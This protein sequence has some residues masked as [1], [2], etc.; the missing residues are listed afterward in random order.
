MVSLPTDRESYLGGKAMQVYIW[1]MAT[2]VLLGYYG[3]WALALVVSVLVLLYR[4]PQIVSCFKKGE[5]YD[6]FGVYFATKS[7][8]FL[9][10]LWLTICL[11]D[12]GA[13]ITHLAS[14]LGVD[15]SQLFIRHH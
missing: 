4:I 3:T 1:R 10:P 8:S 14:Y 5:I 13:V 15:F 12:G 11:L 9:V 2:G 6:A 7:A